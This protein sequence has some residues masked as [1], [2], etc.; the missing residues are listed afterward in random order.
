ML[1]NAVGLAALMAAAVMVSGAAVGVQEKGKEKEKAKTAVTE[2]SDS[3]KATGQKAATRKSKES[4]KGAAE[5]KSK[6]R[7]ASV[8]GRLPTGYAQ[9][10]LT[11]E[12][13]ETILKIRVDHATELAD[14]QKQIEAVRAKIDKE[15]LAVLTSDQKK[16]LTATRE[17]QAAEKSKS[18]DAAPKKS[19]SGRSAKKE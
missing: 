4:D 6:S 1:K 12:Q 10:G 18:E 13:R 5:S 19:A 3:A 8:G 7:T 15:C 17:E 14:L 9:L 11:D 16:Q 2:K